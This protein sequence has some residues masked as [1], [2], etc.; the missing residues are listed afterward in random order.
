[1]RI[2]FITDYM[3]YPP[4]TGDL[5]RNYNLIRRIARH[6]QVS[7]VAFKNA[8]IEDDGVSHMKQFCHRVEAVNL[9]RRHKLVRIPGLFRYLTAGIPIDIEFLQSDM[10]AHRIKRLVYSEAFDIVQI[11]QTRMALYLEALP[12]NC[13]SKNILVF[14]NVASKQYNRIARI[15][16]TPFEK[17]RTRLHSLMLQRWEPRYAERF[18][19]CIAMSELDRRLLMRANPNLQVEVV[20]N[21]VDTHLYQPIES[22]TNQLAVLIVGSMS[23]AP[24]ADGALWFCNNILPY[25][26]QEL[27]KVQVWIVGISPPPS[28]VAL[29]SDD[30]HVTGRVENVVP[31]YERNKVCVVPLR[32][33]GGTRLKILEAMALGRPVVSTSIGCEGLD[34]VDGQHLLIADEPKQFAKKTV[35]L[36]KDKSLY[37]YIATKA[38]ELVV[39][40]Y[41]W[42]VISNKLLEIYSK[43]I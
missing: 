5:I 32:A 17:I 4:I 39:T 13:Y 27:N 8:S 42:D 3:P 28:V 37:H 30:V 19:L 1:M 40:R 21:G 7:L 29:R 33:G 34:L 35:N 24:N 12:P 36:L 23:Y 14:H 41:N 31:Y 16:S 2:L 11:E 22:N 15:A 20:P 6:H 10:M 26:R 9:V 18:D 25:I 38:R 43:V